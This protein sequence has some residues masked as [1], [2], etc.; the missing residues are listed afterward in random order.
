MA[1]RTIPTDCSIPR[2][3]NGA[4]TQQRPEM[5]KRLMVVLL[6]TAFAFGLT[7]CAAGTTK[8]PGRNGDFILNIGDAATTKHA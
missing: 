8:S 6:I 1:I 5:S 3:S 4:M 7:G 2:E